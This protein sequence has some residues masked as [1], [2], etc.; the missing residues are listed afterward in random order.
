M[1]INVENEKNVNISNILLM[2]TWALAANYFILLNQIFQ[3]FNNLVMINLR[4]FYE[5]SPNK[6]SGFFY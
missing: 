2:S 5:K 1:Y 3:N 4:Y 6:N